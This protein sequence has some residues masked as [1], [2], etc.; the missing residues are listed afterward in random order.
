MVFLFTSRAISSSPGLRHFSW[1]GE[2][3]W[4]SL[5][6]N[7]FP[8]P[9]KKERLKE[10]RKEVGRKEGRKEGWKEGRMDMLIAGYNEKTF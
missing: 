10:G 4:D 3:I 5:G 8:T 2:Q 6:L 1:F 7:G 9:G